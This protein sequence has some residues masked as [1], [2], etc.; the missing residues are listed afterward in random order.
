[1]CWWSTHPACSDFFEL[2]GSVAG[3][4]CAQLQLPNAQKGYSPGIFL[5]GLEQPDERTQGALVLQQLPC[6]VP[7]VQSSPAACTRM[8]ASWTTRA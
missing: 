7:R 3:R 2:L 4:V 1:M 6:Q 8:A 5:V